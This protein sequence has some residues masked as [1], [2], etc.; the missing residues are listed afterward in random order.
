MQL[1]VCVCYEEKHLFT[2][3]LFVSPLNWIAG[4]VSLHKYY[5]IVWGEMWR[6]GETESEVWVW[7]TVWIVY[8]IQPNDSMSRI[9]TRTILKLLK[10]V[11]EQKRKR[12]QNWNRTVLRLCCLSLWCCRVLNTPLN[13]SCC[14]CA[15]HSNKTVYWYLWATILNKYIS[16]HFFFVS[17]RFS[18]PLPRFFFFYILIQSVFLCFPS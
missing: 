13:D 1:C 17:L 18:P 16:R 6:S 5:W 10:T 2:Y 3:R 7:V 11:K 8:T 12:T 9:H 15:I 14:L 4:I